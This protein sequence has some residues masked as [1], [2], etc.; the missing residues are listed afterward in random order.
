MNETTSP[1]LLVYS[2]PNGTIYRVF[3]DNNNNSIAFTNCAS[4]CLV[5]NESFRNAIKG[6]LVYVV[7]LIWRTSDMGGGEDS[8]SIDALD[9]K[10]L[11]PLHLYPNFT[12]QALENQVKSQYYKL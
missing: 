8:I 6:H 3:V 11:Y 4:S 2:H 1:I 5:E 9:G 10:V 12:G 7:E